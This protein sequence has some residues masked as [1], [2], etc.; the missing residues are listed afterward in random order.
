MIKDITV[1]INAIFNSENDSVEQV[2]PAIIQ[3]KHELEITTET[4]IILVPIEADI[5]TSDEYHKM[6]RGNL[7]AGKT[8]K[9]RILAANS[10]NIQPPVIRLSNNTPID[11]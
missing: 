8:A 6:F 3:L 2:S 9:T 11:E 1:V 4:D 5:A 7:E 10:F